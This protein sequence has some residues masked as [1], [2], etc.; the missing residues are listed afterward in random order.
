M[1]EQE[2]QE[3]RQHKIEEQAALLFEDRVAPAYELS[4]S[5]NNSNITAHVVA[6]LLHGT[7]TISKCK[8]IMETRLQQ[9]AE[10]TARNIDFSKNEAEAEMMY[11]YFFSPPPLNNLGAGFLMTSTPSQANFARN[12]SPMVDI[13]TLIKFVFPRNQ[14]HPLSTGRLLVFGECGPLDEHSNL[15]GGIRGHHVLNKHELDTMIKHIEIDDLLKIYIGNR[16]IS[17]QEQIDVI[18][19]ADAKLKRDK[20]ISKL[21]V[22]GLLEDLVRNSEGLV[23]FHDMQHTIR[24]FR[25]KRIIRWKRLSAAGEERKSSKKLSK[26]EKQVQRDH[27]KA[28]RLASKKALL[29][30]GLE[31]YVKLFFFFFKK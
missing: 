5:N 17:P 14:Q 27:S 7:N 20:Q 6:L 30:P 31:K 3:R 11:E 9:A 21:Q 2:A 15:R 22:Y 8:D 1:L 29:P 4:H 16:V 13:E 10:K 19:Q 28:L 23:S 25:E 12:K 18:S 26:E 24:V